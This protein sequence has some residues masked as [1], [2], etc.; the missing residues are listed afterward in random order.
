LK[1][2]SSVGAADV[3]AA[4]FPASHGQWLVRKR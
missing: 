2:T 3:R 1:D 4:G